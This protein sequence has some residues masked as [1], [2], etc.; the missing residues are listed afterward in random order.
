MTN[1][2]P[3]DNLPSQLRVSLPAVTAAAADVWPTAAAVRRTT[4]CS[5]PGHLVKL[6]AASLL[7][8]LL[9][10]L[11]LLLVVVLLLL[12]PLLSVCCT[13]TACGDPGTQMVWCLEPPQAARVPHTAQHA[14]VTAVG[15]PAAPCPAARRGTLGRL[16]KLQKGARRAS[17]GW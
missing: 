11:L 6:L 7:L 1:P 5:A 12:L 16:A 9:L 4:C 14:H 8:F 3:Q 2:K 13:S 17:R 10:L 15:C